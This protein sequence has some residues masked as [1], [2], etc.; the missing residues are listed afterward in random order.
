MTE[1]ERSRQRREY[2]QAWK[3]ANR[4]R[5]NAVERTRYD[6][7]GRRSSPKTEAQK[8]ASRAHKAANPE[9]YR[10]YSRRA[11]QKLREVNRAR[12]DAIKLG[13]GCADC[14]YNTH[15]AALD[16]DHVNGEKA[17]GISQAARYRSW[18][19]IKREIAKCIV[20]CANCHRVK[21]A[22]RRV[23]RHPD[24]RGGA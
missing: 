4:D 7:L 3:R 14:G 19:V 5:V 22:E 13:R 8:A 15:P 20:R 24:V 21:T 6:R 11:S 12:L 9:K 17:F 23:S 2:I 18:P 1:A 10:E 16:F